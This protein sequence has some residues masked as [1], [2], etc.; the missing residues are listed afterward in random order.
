MLRY[1]AARIS[2]TCTPAVKYS[3]T[4][5]YTVLQQ[6]GEPGELSLQDCRTMQANSLNMPG[7]SCL[8]SA[9][10]FDWWLHQRPGLCAT[11]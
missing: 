8:L 9:G 3:D 1:D 4:D 2:S 7:C 11:I 5:A 6:P 10:R